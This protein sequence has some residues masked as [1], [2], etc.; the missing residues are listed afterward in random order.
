LKR[1]LIIQ[2]AFI[3]DV[4]LATPLIEKIAHYYKDAEIDFLL[5]K[6]NEALFENHPKLNNILI[7]DKKS[8]KYKKLFKL[9]KQVRKHDYD[10]VINLQRFASTGFLTWL[11][12]GKRKVGFK[13]NPFSFSYDIKN[14][15]FFTEGMH[16]TERNLSLLA[17]FG[18]VIYFKPKLYPTKQNY[19]NVLEYINDEFITIA[20]ASVWYTKQFHKDKWIELINLLQ[21][22]KII[23]LGSPSDADLCN[24]IKT[25]SNHKN[26]INLAGKL[27]FLDSAELMKHAKMNYVN[28]S[29][30]MH[31]ASSV[32]ANV[33][34]V[35]CSTISDFGFG[36]LSD[37]SKIIETENHLECRPCGLHGKKACPEGHFDCSM[38]IDVKKM[39]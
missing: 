5:R 28:D 16:E 36:P 19:N 32:N 39:L 23:L 4:I 12:K 33:T 27:S 26:I 31:I 1:F 25:N 2:T 14:K 34:A 37:N 30:P 8:N 13:Q 15:M 9:I 3:G 18:D 29:A 6:G 24:K 35:Y 38:K 17:D 10:L 22:T 7:W 21:N 20:P 11:S